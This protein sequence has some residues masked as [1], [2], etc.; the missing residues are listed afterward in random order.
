MTSR[1]PVILC[2]VGA[3]PNFVKL[4]PIAD[5]IAAD[6]RLGLH[7]VHTGQHYDTE[8]SGRFFEDLD[9][10]QP[11]VN[12]EVGSGSHTAQT[13]EIML[14]LEPVIAQVQPAA[15][16]VVGDV[17]STLAAALVA[18]KA[19]VRLIHVEAGLRSRDL[20]MPE[21]INRILTDRVSDLLFV[22]ER[23][24]VDNLLRE[25]I[26][27][28]SIHFVGNVMI[29]ALDKALP[30]STPPAN[31]LRAAG[32]EKPD[33]YA[34]ATL[35]RPSNVDDSRTLSALMEV[36][37]EIG[38]DC[39]VVFPIHPRTRSCIEKARLESRLAPPAVIALPPLGYL[40]M[41]GLVA[42]AQAVLT[43]SG[44]LQEETTALGVP[45]LTLRTT[46]ERPV[47]VREGTSAL[48][49]ND[50]HRIRAAWAAI[51]AGETRRGQRPELWDGRAAH[52][53]ATIIANLLT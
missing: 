27:R 49:G 43:D 53:I 28:G 44:G 5:A 24:A 29:D 46:T 6:G 30:R 39:P 40:D 1:R 8:M 9:I 20:T 3:R 32:H 15:V 14:R 16:L 36:F 52:R 41:V 34:V 47:T 22:T 33:R 48:V 38:R 17:N 11:D 45:C 7:V 12:L 4:A 26:E 31:T 51:Q 10:R 37:V 50:P 19:G 13:A 23:D 18:A 25:G 42:G 2:V 21:E 35:H